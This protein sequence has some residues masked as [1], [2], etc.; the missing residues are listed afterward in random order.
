MKISTQN[1][2]VSFNNRKILNNISFSINSGEMIG[3]IGPNGSGKSTLLNS[4]VGLINPQ[5]GKIFLNDKDITLI[6][7][8]KLAKKITIIGQ[9]IPLD[10]HC[11][12]YDIVMLGRLPHLGPFEFET[13]HDFNVVKKM[14]L[15]TDTWQFKDRVFSELSAGEQQRLLIAKALA[16][17]S[18]CLLLDEPTSHLDINQ[19]V[20]ILDL[21]IK[22][23]KE[24]NIAVVMVLHD[25]NLALAYPQKILAIKD[26]FLK[27]E[28]APNAMTSKDFLKDIYGI[29]NYKIDSIWKRD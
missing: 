15:F 22:I 26:G 21:L 8:R 18:E 3:I 19:S 11:K 28:G 6:N 14:M 16:T 10:I 24:N 2:T 29:E 27:Y 13:K 7:K 12:S 9:N 23:S 1:L 20:N 4:I 5:K 17:E 25:L